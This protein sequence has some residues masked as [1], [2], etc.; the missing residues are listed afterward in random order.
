MRDLGENES[1][2][3]HYIYIMIIYILCI[4]IIVICIGDKTSK[5]YVTA[6]ESLGCD[7]M[8]MLESDALIKESD[9]AVCQALEVCQIPR[10]YRLRIY[11]VSSR[12][13]GAVSNMPN[14]VAYIGQ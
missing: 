2:N 11:L 7:F 10:H 12:G 8:Q 6:T 13:L 4:Y 14:L 3:L 9:F 5:I 1:Y